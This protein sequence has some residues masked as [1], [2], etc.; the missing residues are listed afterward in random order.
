MESERGESVEK[1][2]R[3]CGE[4]MERVWR[5]RAERMQGARRDGE[6]T[7]RGGGERWGVR[8]RDSVLPINIHKLT[9]VF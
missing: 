8:E 3:E 5:A 4:S 9:N 6:E 2:W 7:E 1:V